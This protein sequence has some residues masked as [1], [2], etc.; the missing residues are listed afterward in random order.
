[1]GSLIEDP[2]LRDTTFV[3][4]DFETTTPAGHPAQPIEVAVL[5]LRHT[6]TGWTESGRYT[7]LIRPP[8]FA[9]VT[10]ANTAQ[11]R[12]APEQ[13]TNAPTPSLALGGLDQRFADQ[14]RYLL[15]AQH[16]ATESDIIHHQRQQCPR[17]ARIDLID[18]IPLAKH[19]VPGLGNYKLDTLLHY[20]SIPQPAERHRAFADV[21][22]TTEVFIRLIDVADRDGTLGNLAELVKI[23]G[24]TAKANRPIQQQLFDQ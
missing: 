16:A 24:R 17:L 8:D 12:L 21:E 22:V 10:H 13:F 23:A 7:T 19:L 11:S 4:I 6:P 14:R 1:M 15:V 5:A 2:N 3:V 20:F 18:T 9:P